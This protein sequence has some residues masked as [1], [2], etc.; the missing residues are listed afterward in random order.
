MRSRRSPDGR[1]AIGLTTTCDGRTSRAAERGR[2]RAQRNLVR[3]R[4]AIGVACFALLGPCLS[5]AEAD[6]AKLAWLGDCWASEKS[7]PGSGESW[8]P[9]LEAE[10]LAEALHQ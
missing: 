5:A 2:W 7:E 4:L 1:D 10:Q 3:T 9:L 6:I 8:A